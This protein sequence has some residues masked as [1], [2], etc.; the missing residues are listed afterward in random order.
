MLIF[1]Y[2]ILKRYFGVKK[3]CFNGVTRGSRLPASPPTHT[4]TIFWSLPSSCLLKPA[5]LP[6]YL[7]SHHTEVSVNITSLPFSIS[8]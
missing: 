4:H 6:N 3:K 5:F 7:H 8:C 1:D 2:T